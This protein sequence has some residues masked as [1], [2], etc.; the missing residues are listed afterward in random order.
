MQTNCPGILS[1]AR[2]KLQNVSRTQHR[3]AYRNIRWWDDSANAGENRAGRNC[4]QGDDE[5]LI[6]A[7]RHAL[8]DFASFRVSDRNPTTGVK[9][10]APLKPGTGSGWRIPWHGS[11]LEA[12]HRLQSDHQIEG[13]NQVH[14][15]ERLI[16][17]FSFLA[18]AWITQPTLSGC[19]LAVCRE[20]RGS[21]FR[22]LPIVELGLLPTNG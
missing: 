1:T 16:T 20:I 19:P 17:L 11:G 15:R 3:K 4:S 12:P 5:A 7:I 22:M 21:P 6:G 9:A 8:E 2:A 14:S 13:R 18:H 10:A